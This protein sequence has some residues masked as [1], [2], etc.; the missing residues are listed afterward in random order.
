MS[1]RNNGK[2]QHEWW[3]ERFDKWF[4][5]QTN[6]AQKAVKEAI[7]T[8]FLDRRAPQPSGRP[9]RDPSDSPEDS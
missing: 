5:M 9:S 4:E 7:W 2:E 6:D 3:F 8:G 1:Q